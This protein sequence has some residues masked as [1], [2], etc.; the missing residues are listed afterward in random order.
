MRRILAALTFA[1]IISSARAETLEERAAP[2]LG[3]HG[4]RGQSETGFTPSLG[5]QQAP[6]ALIQLFMFREKLRVFEPMNEM[7][8]E[9]TDDDLR[10]FSDFIGKLPKPD[11][12]A[13]AG[14]PARIQRAQALVQQ[15]HCASCHNPDFSGR[16]NVPRIADQREDYLAK[17]MREYKDNSRHGYDGTMAEV[18]QPVTPEQIADLAYYL[19]RLR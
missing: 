5:G 7:A 6:Y 3:C 9:F 15:H 16:D 4:E 12:A 1:F 18:L 13:D 17:T 19:A 10:A 11:A 14:D 2:C 8:K